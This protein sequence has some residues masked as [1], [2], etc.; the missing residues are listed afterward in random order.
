MIKTTK[1]KNKR[2]DLWHDYYAWR[3]I[4]FSDE[5]KNYFIWFEKIER[6]LEL[7]DFIV[8][9]YNLIHHYRIKK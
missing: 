3:P 4:F 9:P 2:L 1:R 6:R 7:I 8:P 5:K